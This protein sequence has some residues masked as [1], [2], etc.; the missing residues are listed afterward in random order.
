MLALT[1]DFDHWP[2]QDRRPQVYAFPTCADPGLAVVGN[3]V[4]GTLG[5][6]F[7]SSRPRQYFLQELQD[8]WKHPLP[9]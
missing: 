6:P 1:K 4:F 9:R 2:V 8:I 5:L 7:N 3:M